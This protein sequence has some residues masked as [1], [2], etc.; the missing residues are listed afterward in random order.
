MLTL[1]LGPD[2]FGKTSRMYEEIE[3]VIK[4]D[5]FSRMFL[6]VPEQESVKAEKALIERF[7]NTVSEKMEVLNFSRLANRVFREAGGITYEYVDA[8]GKDLMIS[9]ILEDLK[10]ETPYFSA[11]SGDEGFVSSLRSELDA[12]RTSG[13]D[14]ER[15]EKLCKSVPEKEVEAKRLEKKLSELCVL[16]SLY[17]GK[18]KH[19]GIDTLDDLSRLCDT[20]CEYDFF[21]N[22]YV[23][24]DGF[25]DFTFPEYKILENIIKYSLGTFLTLPLVENDTEKV[26]SKSHKAYLEL[27]DICVNTQSEIKKIWLEKR[28]RDVSFPLGFLADR[29]VDGKVPEMLIDCKE[30]ITLTSCKTPFDECTY[31]AREIVRLVKNG[32]SFS[33]ISVCSGNISEYG[34]PLRDVFDKYG[35]EYLSNVKESVFVKPFVNLIFS[36][37]EVI[38]SGF[39]LPTVKKYLENP[40][41]PLEK[42]ERYA[43]VN[44]ITSW[45][46]GSSLWKNDKDWVMNPRGYIED[47]TDFDRE[48]IDIV[49]RARR[50]VVKPLR[51][52]SFNLK[53]ESVREKVAGVWNFIKDVGAEKVLKQRLEEFTKSGDHTRA[54]DEAQVWNIALVCLD[55]LVNTAG[56]RNVSLERFLKYMRIVFHDTSFGRIPSS[57]EQVEVGDI[58]FV[59]NSGIKHLFLIGFNEGSF[60]AT[61]TRA[62]VFTEYE[63]EILARHDN[64]FTKE[65]KSDI[66]NDELFQLY[67]AITTPSECLHLVYHTS[68]SQFSD[69]RVSFFAN[70]MQSYVDFAQTSFDSFLAEPVLRDEIASWIVLNRER[71][72]VDKLLDDVKTIDAEFFE[73][74][75]KE[76]NVENFSS[77]NLT[78]EKPPKSFEKSMNMT[79]ARFEA[80]A[81]CPFS[82]YSNYMLSLKTHKKIEF[83]A[84]E[85]GSLVHKVFERVL[86]T[87]AGEGKRLSET[88]AEEIEII[89]KAVAVEYLKS[90]APEISETS[91]RF[92]YLINRLS[93]FAVYVI[94]NMKEE[95]AVS[96]FEP[97]L[98]EEELREDGE[99]TPYTLDLPNGSKLV[100]YGCVD[101]VDL[102]EDEKGKKFL[103]IV[104]YKTKIGGKKFDLNDVIN[105]INLQ[106]LVYLFA[107]WSNGDTDTKS[108]AGIMYM[109]SSRPDITLQFYGDEKGKTDAETKAMQRS[110]LFLLDEKILNAM[111]K[112]L[113]GRIIPVT[114]KKDGGYTNE[115]TLA[116]LEQFGKLK[117]F[118]DKT[119]VNLAMKL[120]KGQV[121]ASPLVSSTLDPCKWCDFK[122]FC[123]YEGRG[124][125][126]KKCK[127][128]WEEIEACQ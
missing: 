90:T 51:D 87:L 106:L 23:F 111:E 75:Q 45:N 105:G 3:N 78:F 103:R 14:A 37:L 56:E 65:L 84:A 11:L 96:E 21:E 9:T 43:L 46:I 95:F 61:N 83:K 107:A 26:F 42:R 93:S 112:G 38:N 17:E 91:R 73:S 113:E 39:Y 57:L 34:A 47:F 66:L 63:K 67:L 118:A 31:V 44:Y 125:E 108:P 15:L 116:T 25:Y 122:A 16:Y 40:Y 100:F 1:I 59:R 76:I 81:K 7:G 85:M 41:L 121:G 102:Y 70:L 77:E 49:N 20:L 6:I 54:N 28:V 55:R 89:A 114:R 8:G 32:V 33:E 62:G 22:S 80:F 126:Y 98:F 86:A 101:R 10:E 124:R 29:I 50:A 71:V 117:R 12:Y 92:K 19:S 115:S 79:Q 52:L 110:G 128:A 4:S 82:F 97:H 109:P 72:N 35:I 69:A 27:C 48:E 58:G 104:D 5:A 74:L 88:P 2:G 13:V 18:I 119:F 127:N 30:S 60:P 120:Q 64:Y 94:E 36:A 68:S 99:I 53:C 24:V 123:R